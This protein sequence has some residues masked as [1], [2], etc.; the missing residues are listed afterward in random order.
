MHR[1]TMD[2][3]RLHRTRHCLRLQP[4]VSRS[5]PARVRLQIAMQQ[6]HAHTIQHNVG[7]KRPGHTLHIRT[8]ILAQVLRPVC[9]GMHCH[10]SVGNAAIRASDL[11]SRFSMGAT[12]VTAHVL[13]VPLAQCQR[14]AR[15]WAFHA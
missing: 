7:C 13:S 1:D 12:Q 8:G 6:P 4:L 3:I 11:C 5:E 9:Y 14:H 15:P 10:N 2:A